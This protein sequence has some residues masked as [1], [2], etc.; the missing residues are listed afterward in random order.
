[1]TP[2]QKR[3]SFLNKYFIFKKVRDV[4]AA[5]VERVQ[6]DE[7]KVEVA[8]D[9]SEGKSLTAVLKSTRKKPK[10]RKMKGKLKL[11]MKKPKQTVTAPTE[12]VEVAVVEEGKLM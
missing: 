6:T 3:I 5:A 10:V 1:M 12:V 4:D 11:K 8:A 7:S 2:D 9:T